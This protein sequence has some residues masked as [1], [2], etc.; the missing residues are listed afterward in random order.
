MHQQCW[1]VRSCQNIIL[2][3]ATTVM[4]MAMIGK[5]EAT[6]N[7]A[8]TTIRIRNSD[9]NAI[10]CNNSIDRLFHGYGVVERVCNDVINYTH[11]ETFGCPLIPL[12]RY[13][14]LGI[15]ASTIL[16]F[17]SELQVNKLSPTCFVEVSNV[18]FCSIICSIQLVEI[19]SIQNV[20]VRLPSFVI[21]L[22]YQHMSIIPRNSVLLIVVFKGIVFELSPLLR[23]SR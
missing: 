10:I 23:S 14:I 6:I 17:S 21:I 22:Q 3:S 1:T 16:I 19:I 13:I 8:N 9:E 4:T 18:M 20:H 11:M 5:E 7:N 2:A 15:I 12:W